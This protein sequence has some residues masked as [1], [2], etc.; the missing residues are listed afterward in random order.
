M[1][2]DMPRKSVVFLAMCMIAN[3][4]IMAKTEIVAHRG[5][6]KAASDAQNSIE[7]LQ[8][9]ATTDGIYASEFDVWRTREGS[10]VVNHDRKKGGADMLLSPDS[11]ILAVELSNGETLPTLDSF[12]KAALDYPRLRLVLE[13]KPLDTLNN[14]DIAAAEIV[15][16]LKKYGL[17]DRTDIISFSINGCL[18][19]VKLCPQLPVYYLDGD[20]APR[21]IKE[22]GL[23]GIDYNRRTIENHPEWI[24]QC[25]DLGLKVNVWT[26]D[27]PQEI[28][29]FADMGVDFITT[30]NPET[31]FDR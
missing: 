11:E 16:M 22:L 7:A 18:A 6:W 8:K 23:A 5:Y 15:D 13:L 1:T 31:P 14:E 4:C 12:L 3:I 24:Q 2:Y 20:L 26:V 19:F 30:N 28:Q 9:A 21:K 29:K 10:L 25:H 17:M 27:D